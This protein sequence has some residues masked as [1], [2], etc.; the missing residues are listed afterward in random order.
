MEKLLT[1]VEITGSASEE[2]LAKDIAMH[3][4]AAAPE[5]LSPEKVPAEVVEHEKEIAR[6]QMKGKPANIMDKIVEGKM[7]AY[8]G[9]VCLTEQKY[10]RDDNLSITDLVSKKGKETG[11]SLMVTDFLRWGVGQS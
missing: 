11:K 6:S 9:S 4:A 10:I 2:A 1:L 3:V 5:F 8:Y 7:H